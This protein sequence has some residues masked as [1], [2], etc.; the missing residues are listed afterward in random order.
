MGRHNNHCGSGGSKSAAAGDRSAR[1]PALLSLSSL[2][3]RSDVRYPILVDL[4]RLDLIRALKRRGGEGN[5][6]C[7]R[8]ATK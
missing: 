7:A 1:M 5:D 2:V 4:L 3:D 8:F 6:P